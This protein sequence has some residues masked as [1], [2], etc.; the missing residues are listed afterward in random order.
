MIKFIKNSSKY[1][2]A[3]SM[4]AF[5]S[6]CGIEGNTGENNVE[7]GSA[8]FVSATVLKDLNDSVML[9]I[10]KANVPGHGSDVNAFGYKAVEIIYNTKGQNDEDVVAS[11]LLVIPT[12]SALTNAVLAQQ[13]KAFS[14]SMLCDNH[15][16]IFP[17]EEAPTN[18]EKAGMY[19]LAISMTGVA[20]FA[21]ILPDYIG[22]GISNDI[23]HPYI[24]KKA[25]ARS[26]V[27]MIKA[28][29]NY[30]EENGVILNH[31][32]YISG[33]SEGGYNAMALA[34]SVENGAIPTVTLKGVAPMAGP[35]NVEDLANIEINATHPMQYPA[36][37]GYLADS[38]SFYYDDLNLSDIVV[39]SDTTKFHTLF[40]G[41]VNATVIQVSLGLTTF[42]GY[43]G[44][45]TAD[46]LFKTTFI[47][48]YQ[49]TPN[50]PIHE[51]FLENNLDN[52][53]PNSKMNLIHCTDDEIIPFSE[54]N[55]TY[56]K[57]IASG[58]SD[59][60]LTELNA[61]VIPPSGA[62]YG[63]FVHGRC[64]PAAYGQAIAWFDA[65][66]SGAI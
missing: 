56:H 19:S 45:Y 20:G 61:T 64:G 8:Q 50:S 59:I 46:A 31:Q 42:G 32:L 40:N 54:S 49:S 24:M 10:I 14:V 2:L 23:A 65:I 18:E 53:T 47:D 35:H 3:L 41:D 58:A 4:V 36:F 60:L 12:A 44:A 27:D 13:G 25:S 48:D 11:G 63:P 7:N 29:M 30:M 15:G 22:Y 6:A 37:L 66:R 21:A 33:Y 43:F 16:T 39:E 62:G 52:W 38:Y 55:N 28:S 26:S 5:L 57:F 1:L 51:R 9:G 34:Q 17:N